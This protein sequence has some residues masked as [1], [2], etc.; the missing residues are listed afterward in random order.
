MEEVTLTPRQITTTLRVNDDSTPHTVQVNR[1]DTDTSPV[2]WRSCSGC[3]IDKRV[4]LFS[5]QAGISAVTAG[6]CMYQ[7]ATQHGC[8]SQGL[9]SGILSLI[10]GTWLPQP[11]VAGK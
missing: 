7:L 11:K 3:L 8:E 6:F 10:L 2:L 1:A 9:Y 4:L 5:A